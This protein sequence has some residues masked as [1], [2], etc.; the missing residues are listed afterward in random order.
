[1]FSAVSV[2]ITTMTLLIPFRG[3]SGPSGAEKG[4]LPLWIFEDRDQAPH[5]LLFVPPGVPSTPPPP[6]SAFVCFLFLPSM[7]MRPTLERN[8]GSQAGPCCDSSQRSSPHSGRDQATHHTSQDTSRPGL[9]THHL[10][11]YPPRPF[12]SPSP[13]PATLISFAAPQTFQNTPASG[14]SP[15]IF[16]P[17]PPPPPRTQLFQTFQSLDKMSPQPFNINGYFSPHPSEAPD[18]LSF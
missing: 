12:P 17:A 13:A 4:T 10:C 9:V 6:L 18:F 7:F 14:P 15:L 11:P 2:L 3:F 1:M 16:R 5:V 8:L